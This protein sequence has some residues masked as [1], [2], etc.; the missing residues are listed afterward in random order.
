M[1]SNQLNNVLK[2]YF[3]EELLV[4]V[5]VSIINS[6][7]INDTYK[8]A[9]NN[10]LF[11]LQKINKKVFADPSNIQS[12][13]HVITSFFEENNVDFVYPLIFKSKSNNLAAKYLSPNLQSI[14]KC[15]VKK[16]ATIILTLLCM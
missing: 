3:D 5:S 6:G 4:N 10:E 14:N 13:I 8:I 16:L 11:I 12:N 2:Q 7:L 15:L 9:V 1:I